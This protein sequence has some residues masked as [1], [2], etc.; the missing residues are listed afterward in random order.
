MLIKLIN[1]WLGR[2][3]DEKQNEEDGKKKQACCE[4]HPASGAGLVPLQ[5]YAT[6]SGAH[7]CAR[8]AAHTRIRR[9]P[10]VSI[11]PH[12]SSSSEDEDRAR[13]ASVVVTSDVLAQ[14]AEDS[15]KVRVLFLCLLAA[16]LGCR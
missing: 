8:C 10:R 16:H 9:A 1:H 4:V 6:S 5:A 12:D 13:F 3:E 15:R 11:M 14:S 2:P 7:R